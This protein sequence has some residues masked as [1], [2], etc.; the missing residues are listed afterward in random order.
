[1]SIASIT[2]LSIAKQDLKRILFI[3]QREQELEGDC[4]LMK[5]SGSWMVRCIMVSTPFRYTHRRNIWRVA[6]TKNKLATTLQCSLT[7][8]VDHEMVA[9][10]WIGTNETYL[11]SS[12]KAVDWWCKWRSKKWELSISFHEESIFFSKI[13]CERNFLVANSMFVFDYSV[14]LPRLCMNTT[15]WTILLAH[16]ASTCSSS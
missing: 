13:W 1:M 5:V 12:F 6:M 7:V 2:T 10:K 8:V 9:L 11:K 4:T 16:P 3:V 14:Q 15:K